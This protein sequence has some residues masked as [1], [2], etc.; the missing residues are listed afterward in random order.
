MIAKSS[1]KPAVVGSEVDVVVA[2]VVMGVVVVMT[3]P[4]V[5]NYSS[6]QEYFL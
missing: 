4:V 3:I 6:V 1:Y 2:L 5:V